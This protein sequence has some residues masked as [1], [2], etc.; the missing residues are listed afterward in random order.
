MIDAEIKDTFRLLTKC[1]A[2]PGSLIL[3]PLNS[4][5]ASWAFTES[6]LD[7]TA[8]LNEEQQNGN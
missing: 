2:V 8:D 1:L 7:L 6:A 3:E 4:P 5:A